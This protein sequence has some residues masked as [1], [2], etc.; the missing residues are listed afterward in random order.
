MN[1]LINNLCITINFTYPLLCKYL[2]NKSIAERVNGTIKNEL[3]KGMRFNSVNEV[4]KAVAAAVHFYNNERPH[5][6]LNML[7][8]A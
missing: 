6:S 8:P 3:L 2:H 1:A 5:M 4:R 7:T